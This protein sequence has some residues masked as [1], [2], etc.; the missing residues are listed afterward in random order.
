MVD[1]D[2]RGLRYHMGGAAYSSSDGGAYERA[3]SREAY[4]GA[5]TAG[6]GAA[7]TAGYGN[8]SGSGRPALRS[9]GAI[10]VSKIPAPRSE[11]GWGRGKGAGRASVGLQ[12]LWRLR[13]QGPTV[14]AVSR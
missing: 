10:R 1:A 8:R 2:G 3:Y 6:D 12:M 7:Y 4:G 11:Y 9:R 5:Y 13:P 14:A